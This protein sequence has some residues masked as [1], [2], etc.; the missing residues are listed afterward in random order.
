MRRVDLIFGIAT[1]VIVV[2]CLIFSVSRLWKVSNGFKE[3]VS[4]LIQIDSNDMRDIIKYVDY[5][6][7]LFDHLNEKNQRMGL[8]NEAQYSSSFGNIRSFEKKSSEV[9]DD[10]QLRLATTSANLNKKIK[11]IEIGREITKMIM[12]PA[13]ILLVTM[14]LIGSILISL[15]IYSIISLDSF[16]AYGQLG[17]A[18]MENNGINN[19]I[20]SGAIEKYRASSLYSF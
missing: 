7:Y 1:G 8:Q 6:K 4:I 18:F 12:R 10:E 15:N 20:A 3:L 13:V 2:G 11:K 9:S 14:T 17:F 16:A 19:I 5:T